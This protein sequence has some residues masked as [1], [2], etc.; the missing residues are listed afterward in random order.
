M[1]IGH[2][3]L[4]F[5]ENNL[6]KLEIIS[7]Y[8]KIVKSHKIKYMKNGIGKKCIY[9]AIL[10]ILIVCFSCTKEERS[11]VIKEELSKSD[12]QIVETTINQEITP[13]YIINRRSGKVHSYTH[14]MNCGM[15]EHN[16]L[17]SNEDIEEILKNEN[18]DICLTCFAGLKLNLDK[19]K[20]N[21]IVNARI[22]RD[23]YNKDVTAEDLVFIRLDQ[24]FPM[25]F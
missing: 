4:K 2:A 13:K 15:S 23:K 6:V 16:K 1:S 24:N 8:K 18:Y 10:M 5:S 11:T 9:L 20:T 3:E 25:E 22:A 7:T 14:G 12:S 17:E 19:Y 21:K